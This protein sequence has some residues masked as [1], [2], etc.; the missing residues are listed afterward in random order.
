[1]AKKRNRKNRKSKFVIQ[2]GPRG[3]VSRRKKGTKKQEFIRKITRDGKVSKKE[4]RKAQKKGISPNRI[5]RDY[6]KNFKKSVKA[7]RPDQ[8]RPLDK[9]PRYSPLTISRGAQKVSNSARPKPAPRRAPA[10]RQAPRAATPAAPTT[11]YSSQIDALAGNLMAQQ[12]QFDQSY[13][14]PQVD[15]ESMMIQ[16]REAADQR[17]LEAEQRYQDMI[18]AQQ[19][20]EAQAAA[21]REEAARQAAISRQTMMANQMRAA[22]AAPQLKFGAPN[23]GTNMYGTKA[24]KRRTDLTPSVAQGINNRLASA[25]GGI[26]V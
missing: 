25:F 16:F 15:F 23:A 26:N 19:Q 9:P 22:N 12:Q 5:Q 2:F 17:A 13:S 8:R 24:F 7:F 21:E 18:A 20:A 6:D 3:Q 11:P 4:M 10:P 1:M 14:Q